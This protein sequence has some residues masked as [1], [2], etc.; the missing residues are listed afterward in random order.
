MRNGVY[1]NYYLF[2]PMLLVVA[3]FSMC[4]H[5]IRYKPPYV[6][7]VGEHGHEVQVP[8]DYELELAARHVRTKGTRE[9]VIPNPELSR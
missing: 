8:D 9:S 7:D 4:A 1:S 5:Y 6:S 2:S 3:P